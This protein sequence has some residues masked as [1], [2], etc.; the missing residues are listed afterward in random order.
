[1]DNNE[2]VCNENCGCD[3]QVSTVTLTLEDGSILECVILGTFDVEDNEY[4]ALLPY[5][6]DEPD[7]DGEVLLYKF[8]QNDEGN[9]NLSLIEDVEEF[10]AVSEVFYEL[11][12]DDEEMDDEE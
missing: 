4:I 12:G 11:F 8:S 3:E 7:E 5:A 6:A 2:H 10:E 1:M 9:V